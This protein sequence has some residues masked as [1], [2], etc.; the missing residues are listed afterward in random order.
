MFHWV[1]VHFVDLSSVIDHFRFIPIRQ[2][3]R[4]FFIQT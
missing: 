2:G 4:E 3:R 1:L